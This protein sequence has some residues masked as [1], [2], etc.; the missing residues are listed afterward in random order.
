[1]QHHQAAQSTELFGNLLTIAWVFRIQYH[2]H[3][4]VHLNYIFCHNDVSSCIRGL[5]LRQ[6]PDL[7]SVRKEEIDKGNGKLH[8]RSQKFGS[9]AVW[10][11]GSTDIRYRNFEVKKA[12]QDPKPATHNNHTR[13]IRY[14][15]PEKQLVEQRKQM[16][17][18]IAEENSLQGYKDGP[19]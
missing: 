5:L 9:L 16:G 12:T 15:K 13:G 2:D 4:W 3:D 14:I 19:M 18:Y 8:P 11:F 7:C 10:Q 1:M 17:D 6:L